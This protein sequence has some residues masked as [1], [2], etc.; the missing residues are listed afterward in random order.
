MWIVTEH[1]FFTFVVDR[2]DDTVVH[3][4]ARVREDLERNFPGVEVIEKPG[5]DYY[6][7]AK[8]TKVQ[9]AERMTQMIMDDTIKGHFKDVALAKS[10]PTEHGNRRSAYY[11]FWTAMAALQP[12]APYSRT[13]RLK[14]VVKPWTPPKRDTRPGT[15]Q[16]SLP[17]TGSESRGALRAG[18]Y[19]WDNRSWQGGDPARDPEPMSSLADELIELGSVIEDDAAWWNSLTPEEQQVHLDEAE[20]NARALDARDEGGLAAIGFSDTLPGPRDW[21]QVEA[22]RRAHDR[23]RAASLRSGQQPTGNGGGRKGRRRGRKNR[24][25]QRG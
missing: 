18:D 8:I 15:G 10:S 7:R 14:S 21:A 4:R 6:F 3:L 5:A 11:G 12:Y 13:P 9:L 24:H 19:D 16:T 22:D 17:Y 25:N 23:D 1:G 20:D 2:K